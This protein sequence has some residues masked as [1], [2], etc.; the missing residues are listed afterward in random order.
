MKR[1]IL[2]SGLLTALTLLFLF[3]TSPALAQ[4][5]KSGWG[6]F[7]HPY[8]PGEVIVKFSDN[9]STT[10]R[11]IT[12]IYGLAVR[13]SL[14]KGNFAVLKLPDYM[15][16]EDA[17]SSISSERGVEYV[18]PNYIRR[19]MVVPDDPLYPSQWGLQ[20]T[21]MADAW[22][23]A[24][25][26]GTILVAV[27]DTGIDLNHPDLQ[28]NLWRNPVESPDGIDNDHNGLVDDIRGWDFINGDNDPSDDNGHGTHVSGIIGAV[29]NNGRGVTGVNWQVSL[30]P[31]KILDADGAG[32]VSDEILAISYAI[33]KG[34]DVINAS[35]GGSNFFS[36]AERDAI[37]AALNAGIL[38]VAA[39]GNGGIDFI[40]DDN[41][42]SPFYPSGYGLDNIISVTA[43]TR[44]GAIATYANFGTTSVDLGAP[45]DGILSTL[46]STYGSLSGT[47]MA[48]AF[49][50]GLA[51]LLQSVYGNNTGFRG[52][53]QMILESVTPAGALQGITVTGGILNGA[54]AVS[55][56][57]PPDGLAVRGVTDHTVRL[58]WNDNSTLEEGFR[59]MRKEGTGKYIE[60]GTV[61]AMNTFEDTGLFD[62]TDYTYRVVAYN[63]WIGESDPSGEV[64][65]VTLL[66]PPSGLTAEAVST[67]SVK[68]R[69]LDN[70]GAEDGY[71][72]ERSEE[73]GGFVEIARLG[74]NVTEFTDQG[75]R[76]ST[77]YHYRVR[78]FGL[79]AGES[80]WSNE[81]SVK[82]TSGT[83]PGPSGGGGGGGC[84]V[85]GGGSEDGGLLISLISFLALL[86]SRNRR[87]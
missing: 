50:S 11:T 1:D 80:S 75:L 2:S 63:S 37:Q 68:L 78:A 84:A 54:R 69:W 27:I 71:L 4:E 81:V 83:A 8:V 65:A 9:N 52:I 41:D 61:A 46:P 85:T 24:R 20:E 43:V 64:S 36:N 22:D 76:S 17:V 19:A 3:F 67:D 62:G 31:L 77:T 5:G 28:A 12:G 51:G 72:I 56:L 60:A 23:H 73:E 47:S 66:S 18:E 42:S 82:T 57:L 29:G 39:A 86:R 44:T 10:L 34:V 74:S 13:H 25:G 32:S 26:E 55:A 7:Y 40:G 16:V 30:V 33:E 14:L 79:K 15:S 6:R 58:E 59:I 87:S 70:S 35:F 49:V 48:T 21:G 53:R 38:F 45:G